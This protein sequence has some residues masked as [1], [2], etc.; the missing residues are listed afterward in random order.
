MSKVGGY[1]KKEHIEHDIKS[2]LDPV[3]ALTCF[4]FDCPLVVDGYCKLRWTTIGENGCC[5]FYEQW[6]KRGEA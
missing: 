5:E 2:S 1:V 6:Q 4:C 3:I